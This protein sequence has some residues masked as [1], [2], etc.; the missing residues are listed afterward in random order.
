ML[1]HPRDFM[2]VQTSRLLSELVSQ[3]SRPLLKVNCRLD[4]RLVESFQ[5]PLT[6]LLLHW[7]RQIGLVL[8]E[9]YGFCH[10]PE[11]APART[12]A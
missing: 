4:R 12:K 9:H 7:H 2:T 11:D 5:P 8:S 6:V 10:C 3:S 1:Q